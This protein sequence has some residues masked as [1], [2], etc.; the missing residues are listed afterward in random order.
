MAQEFNIEPRVPGS[1]VVG[2]AKGKLVI[3][4]ATV[5]ERGSRNERISFDASEN[6]VVLEVGKRGSGK[7]YGMGALL[8]GFAVGNHDSEIS[9]SKESRGVVLLDPLDIHWTALIPLTPEGPPGL[10]AQHE[11]LKSCKGLEVEPISAQ[12]FMPAGYSTPID[13]PGFLEY[14]VPVS[15][16]DSSDWALLLRTD[17]VTE[18]RGRLLDEAYMKVK[19]LGW[20]S[21]DGQDCPATTLYTIADLVNCIEQDVE[22]HQFY[23]RQTRR[24]VVQ[25]LRALARTELF[26]SSEGTPLTDVIR[27]G[28]LS[29]LCLGRLPEDVRTVLA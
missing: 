7:S 25:P 29:V 2:S 1:V 11:I 9:K 5:A 16:L 17:L 4:A 28:V 24:S 23:D 6:F 10:R 21:A 14:K 18:P 12:V 22:I 20:C 3:W 19:V 8:E 15:Q 27:A 26:G 13:H